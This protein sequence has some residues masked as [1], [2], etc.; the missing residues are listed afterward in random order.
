MCERRRNEVYRAV[1]QVTKV[2]VTKEAG[3]A[4]TDILKRFQ[5]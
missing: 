4:S 2:E 3:R 1:E 5:V